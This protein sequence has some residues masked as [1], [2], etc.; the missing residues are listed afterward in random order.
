[1]MTNAELDAL[2]VRVAK[3]MGLPIVYQDDNPE[4][5]PPYLLRFSCDGD[6]YYV[7][8]LDVTIPWH[9]TRDARCE[10]ILAEWVMEQGYTVHQIMCCPADYPGIECCAIIE[11]HACKA[12]R[13]Q[14][15]SPG[16]ALCLAVVEA[17]G[18]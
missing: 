11:E 13:I 6:Y 5:E 15:A 2:D 10:R 16:I 9:P 18:E 7:T 1:M 8:E 4:D 17:F 14:S 12:R 3:L